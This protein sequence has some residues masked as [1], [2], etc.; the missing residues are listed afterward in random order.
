MVWLLVHFASNSSWFDTLKNVNILSA[1]QVH[2]KVRAAN[3]FIPH[4]DEKI[5]PILFKINFKIK[6]LLPWKK[7]G[8]CDIRKSKENKK[9]W[10]MLGSM[11]FYIRDTSNQLFTLH[12]KITYTSSKGITGFDYWLIKILSLHIAKKYRKV[13]KYMLNTHKSLSTC[14]GFGILYPCWSKFAIFLPSIRG[15]GEPP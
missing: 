13:H 2:L 11:S 14:S 12:W 3:L 5:N 1:F 7:H 6:A 4:Y 9:V 15:Y 10:L 8:P